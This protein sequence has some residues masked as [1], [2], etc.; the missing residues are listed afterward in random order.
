M[1]IRKASVLIN[2]ACGVKM[3]SVKCK[4]ANSRNGKKWLMAAVFRT[5][6]IS[7]A[8]MSMQQGAFA[9]TSPVSFNIPAGTLSGAIAEFGRQSGV[10]VSYPPEFA[11]G[12][13]SAG[14]KGAVS[15]EAALG[16]ILQGSGL[17]YQFVNIDSV[18]L[19][20]GGAAA[21]TSASATDDSLLLGTITVTSRAGSDP[22]DA[23]WQGASSRAHL[24]AEQVEH[25]SGTSVGDFLS[26][27]PGVLNGDGRNSGA[28]DVNIRGLQGQGRVPVLVDG[29]SQETTVY[30]GYN[31]STARTYID[32]DFIGSVDIEKGASMGADSTGAVGG[33]VRMSTIG[34]K[35]ILLPGHDFGVRLKGN[36]N[37]NSRSAPSPGTTGG[38]TN[39][40]TYYSWDEFPSGFGD[41]TG[42]DRPATLKPTGGSGSIAIAGTTDAVDVVAA[43]AQR[44]NGNYYAGKRGSG[45]AH[46]VISPPVGEWN[47]VVVS[48]GKPLTPYRAGEQVLNTSRDSESWLL[49]T[50]IRLEGGHALEVGYSRYLS[51]YGNI[52]GSQAMS[53]FGNPPYQSLKSTIDLATW[54]G[55]YSWKPEDSNLI[56][57]KVD[58]F[59]SNVDNRV[60]SVFNSSGTLYPQ[61][62]WAG[63]DRWGG[64]ASNTSRF[65]SDLADVSWQ[66]G[67]SFTREN[68]GLP[69][70]VPQEAQLSARFGWRKEYSGFTTLEVKPLDWVTLSGNLRYSSFETFDNSPQL[71]EPISRKDHGWSPIVSLMVEPLDGFQLYSKYGS[72][73][74]SPSIFESL[75]GASFMFPAAENPVA[76][77]RNNSLELGANYLMD[78]VFLPDDKLRFHGGWFS[79]HVNNY[80]TRGEVRRDRP[81]G[82][83]NYMLG[84]QNLDYADMR[85]FEL[86][87]QYD[88]GQVFGSVA[89]N[90][91][92]DIM[93]CAREGVLQPNATRCASGGLY[94]SFSQQQVPPKDT[95]TVN[96]GSR[97][98]NDDLTVGTRVTYIGSRFVEGMGATDN[99]G[100]VSGMYSIA[101]S[102]WNPYT[103]VDL[104]AS[105][106][107]NQNATFDLSVDNLTDRYYVDALNTIPVPA[108]GRTVRGGVTLKF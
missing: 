30:Q 94:N 78:G 96:L 18:T 3:K 1:R 95:L 4:R 21:N 83:A 101:P 82:S 99:S 91:Y 58:T 80:I 45:Y 104:Y 90:H 10:Q 62:F 53:F 5:S 97:F 36:F 65:Y 67:G 9:Q 50:K 8:L 31:G 20:N 35:D 16:R 23:P 81:D 40:G 75:T 6:A 29:A 46:A 77:E 102:N 47:E 41:S 107:L 66:Y 42:M 74:R 52:L 73:L 7:L 69:D 15:A 48:D 13:Q 79:N 33:I 26:G 108:P 24:S 43:Y 19:V 87:A 93:F 37:T 103:L 44:Y 68:V 92:T 49:K 28:V 100:Q 70:G 76:P 51:T 88:S 64:N 105:Y 38:L 14:V 57:M 60:N 55:R 84:R 25:F 63:S 12:K 34:V 86:S 27:I 54:T 72:V 39:L 61:Y 89:W 32:P 22:A 11:A 98:F 71:G 59:Y 17:S 56:D 106:K 2:N 85:G